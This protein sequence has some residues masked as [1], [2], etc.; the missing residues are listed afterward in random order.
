MS[1][2]FIEKESYKHKLAK[3]LLYQWLVNEEERSGDYCTFGP[4]KWRANYGVFME[5]KFYETS[6]IYYFECSEGIK[7]RDMENHDSWPKLISG[8]EWFDETFNRGKILFVPDIVIFHKGC[9]VYL[10][11]VVHKSPVSSEKLDKI[12]DFFNGG[13]CAVYQVY[14]DDILN[15]CNESDKLRFDLIAEL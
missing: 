8:N 13:Y 3:E 5:L 11:E 14:A 4:L 6:S 10:I 15:K 7:E 1:T 2:P 12:R 9:P